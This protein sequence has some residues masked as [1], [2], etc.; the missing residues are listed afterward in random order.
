MCHVEEGRYVLATLDGKSRCWL[1]PLRLSSPHAGQGRSASRWTDDGS[2]CCLTDLRRSA[3][4]QLPLGNLYF[5]IAQGGRKARQ[6][7]AHW[8]ITALESVIAPEA[9]TDTQRQAFEYQDGT[10]IEVPRWFAVLQ[11]HKLETF[12]K[13]RFGELRR[14]HRESELKRAVIELVLDEIPEL[15]PKAIVDLFLELV[16]SA[17][18]SVALAYRQPAN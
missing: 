17:L 4:L 16:T 7:L 3:V 8:V 5:S 1:R 9:R 12:L 15:T 11:G 10:A 14:F 18:T 13:D 6:P 2:F